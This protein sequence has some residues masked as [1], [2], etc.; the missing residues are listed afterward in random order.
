VAIGVEAIDR[1]S[2][3]TSEQAYLRHAR[4]IAGTHHE[5]WDGSG[6]PMGLKGE[7]IPLE[8]RLMAIADVY[9]ALISARPYKKP[10]LPKEA[11]KII[12]EGRGSHFDPVLTDVFALVADR[13]AE[14]SQLHR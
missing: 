11:E 3:K 13:F 12:L 9:D 7:E 10:I 14:I 5:K 8:G 4:I 1:I 6:Y 2:K